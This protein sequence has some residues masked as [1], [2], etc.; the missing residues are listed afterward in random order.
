MHVVVC[1]SI[2]GF[3]GLNWMVNDAANKQLSVC[4]WFLNS[5]PWC[6]HS[7]NPLP[8]LHCPKSDPT[9]PD[10]APP[11]PGSGIYLKSTV[12]SCWFMAFKKEGLWYPCQLKAPRVAVF[13]PP[14]DKTITRHLS[15]QYI[16][17]FTFSDQLKIPVRSRIHFPFA[18]H[19]TQDADL[20]TK[21]CFLWNPFGSLPSSLWIWQWYGAEVFFKSSWV[22]MSC[23]RR[24]G[25]LHISIFHPWP[26]VWFHTTHCSTKHAYWA[27][28]RSQK[29]LM[30][31]YSDSLV[32]PSIHTSHTSRRSAH[33]YIHCYN[34]Q[35]PVQLA[36]DSVIL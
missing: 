15:T 4:G 31:S 22:R 27:E 11:P 25:R 20:S 32:C 21:F 33:M 28:C 1:F 26:T 12:Y 17:M 24:G 23:V 19:P 10:P 36:A 5:V 34:S 2:K 8:A 14:S 30:H 9:P 29:A 16:H 18:F 6:H 7:H 13:F 35:T 3:R